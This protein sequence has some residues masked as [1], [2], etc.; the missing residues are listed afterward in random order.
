MVTEL[1]TIDRLE[2]KVTLREF[3]D[4]FA[5]ADEAERVAKTLT[6]FNKYLFFKQATSLRGRA[7]ILETAYRGN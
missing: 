5:A 7:R 6:G 3:S 1:F 2:K 4:L